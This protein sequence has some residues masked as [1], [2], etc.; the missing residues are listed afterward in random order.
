MT[1]FIYFC[2]DSRGG[3]QV[4]RAEGTSWRWGGCLKEVYPQVSKGTYICKFQ[5]VK[6]LFMEVFAYKCN[7]SDF[8]AVTWQDC[9]VCFLAY[10]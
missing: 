10:V 4:E 5:I 1:K 3:W 7:L 6:A 8:V 2:T 9:M